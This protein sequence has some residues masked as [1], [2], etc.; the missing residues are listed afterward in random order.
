MEEDLLPY[1]EE[2]FKECKIIDYFLK[3]LDEIKYQIEFYGYICEKDYKIFSNLAEKTLKNLETLK[4]NLSPYKDEPSNLYLMENEILKILTI[5]YTTNKNLYPDCLKSIK[6]SINPIA[7]NL[8][9]TKKNLLNHSIS[10]LKQTLKTNNR[11]ELKKYLQ[12]NIE[13]VMIHTFRGLFNLHQ[14]ILIYSKKKNNLF[15][16]IKNAIEKKASPEEIN[17]VINDV[18]ERKYAEKYKVK[19]EPIHFGNN[20]YKT[21]LTDES[22]DVMELSNSFLKYTMVFIK[23]IQIRKKLVKEIGVFTEMVRK[24]N[25]D[26]LP[27]LKKICEKITSKTKNLTH[28]SPGIINSWNLVFSS[29]NSIYTSNMTYFQYF[30]DVFSSNLSKHLDECNEEYKNFQKKWEKY[31]EKIKELTKKYKKY[32]HKMKIS[33]DEEETKENKE[34]LEEYNNEKKKREEKLRN[35]LTIDC[36]DFLDS[37]IPSLRDSELKRINEIKDFTEKFKI[38]MKKNLEEYLENTENEYDN[39]ASI[40]LFDEIQNMFE[41]QLESLEIKDIE[42]YM[43]SL[44][45]KISNIDFNDNLA[46]SA[47]ISLAEYYEHNE[48]DEGFDFSGGEM[49]NPF[50]NKIIDDKDIESNH[51]DDKEKIVGKIGTLKD[52]EISS[53]T[54]KNNNN[55]ENNLNEMN[56]LRGVENKTPSFNYNISDDKNEN[57]MDNINNNGFNKQN[58]FNS[59]MNMEEVKKIKNEND[60]NKKIKAIDSNSKFGKNKLS[61]YDSKKNIENLAGTTLKCLRSGNIDI[62]NDLDSNNEQ[63]NDTNNDDSFPPLN[64][65]AFEQNIM[66]PIYPI[67]NSAL[68]LND[69]FEENENQ[70]EENNEEF[71]SNLPQGINKFK[72]IKSEIKDKKPITIQKIRN[73]DNTTLNYG[74]LCIIGLFCLKSLFSTNNFFSAETFLNLVI[75]GIIGFVM[76]KTQFNK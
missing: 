47:R 17:I 44:K 59:K 13:L 71:T 62:N 39:A 24:K 54:D 4:S 56:Y 14:L 3:T 36:N 28:S 65:E 8:E 15:L 37:N 30:E 6:S 63:N 38:A 33:K 49:E 76:Y 22:N 1:K 10:M 66:S 55:I 72:E 35:Y 23:C 60:L 64:V 12:D 52:D 5:Y 73:Q 18:S 20:V 67:K 11:I 26:L 50:G 42:N 75:L 41:G 7:K 61:F 25:A 58:N 19:Y 51:L 29:W 40:E 70:K 45:E 31:A 53:I 9:N 34:K 46:E 2:F 43:E 32:S 21:L 27:N 69:N 74:I 57:K 68:P 48:F 16:T